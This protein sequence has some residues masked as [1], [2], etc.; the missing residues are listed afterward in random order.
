MRFVC[1]TPHQ[2]VGD[3]RSVGL[4]PDALSFLEL[5]QPFTVSTREGV[6]RLKVPGRATLWLEPTNNAAEFVLHG[7]QGEGEIL[8]F[9]KDAEGRTHA[10]VSFIH[11]RELAW[12]QRPFVLVAASIGTLLGGSGWVLLRRRR[13]K[14]AA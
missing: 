9:R 11:L 14:R 3:Y 1:R 4:A 12:H 5:L 2:L 13:S 8:H 10:Y 7:G 6:L